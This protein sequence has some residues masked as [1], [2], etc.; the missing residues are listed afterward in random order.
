MI[1]TKVGNITYF[2]T[3]EWWKIIKSRGVDPVVV[4]THLVKDTFKSFL[5]GGIYRD[6]AK[7][8]H[9]E[10]A[11]LCAHGYYTDGVWVYNDKTKTHR[12]DDWVRRHDGEYAVLMLFV[13]NAE[14]AR[15][16][17]A[18][19]SLLVVPE[20]DIYFDIDEVLTP[21]G[22]IY[23]F[24]Q[25]NDRLPPDFLQGYTGPFYKNY[26]QFIILAPKHNISSYFP[27]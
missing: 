22:D 6:I 21:K 5:E 1:K 11:V 27:K 20:G 3:A 25:D 18:R 4:E 8:K 12:V 14:S 2:I 10:I 9:V 16:Q 17:P 23:H 13:C 7:D 24:P 15:L 26:P 19:G